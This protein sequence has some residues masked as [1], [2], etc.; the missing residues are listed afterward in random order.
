MKSTMAWLSHIY[1]QVYCSWM[2]L[3]HLFCLMFSFSI[4]FKI[5][6]VCIMFSFL[7]L[8]LSILDSILYVME[9]ILNIF[10]CLFLLSKIHEKCGHDLSC[11][12]LCFFMFYKETKFSF[13][14]HLMFKLQ[15]LLLV[16]W[17]FCLLYCYSVSVNSMYGKWKMHILVGLG[18]NFNLE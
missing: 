3:L 16:E 11:I 13:I 15:Q 8:L 2:C 6:E 14:C 5:E 12:S 4:G 10:F 17:L 1:Q 7:I 18:S 9:I